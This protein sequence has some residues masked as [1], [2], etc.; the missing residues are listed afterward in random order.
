MALCKD[1]VPENQTCSRIVTLIFILSIFGCIKFANFLHSSANVSRVADAQLSS[2]ASDDDACARYDVGSIR[3]YLFGAIPFFFLMMFVEYIVLKWSKMPSSGAQFTAVDTWSSIAMGV[4]QVIVLEV[5]LRAVNVRGFYCSIFTRFHDKLFP[6]SVPTIIGQHSWLGY[7][8][9]I[10]ADDFVYYWFHRWSHQYGWLW[11]GHQVHHSS[12]HFNLSTALR[13]SYWQAIL[14]SLT[15]LIEAPFFHPR[16]HFTVNMWVT[17]YQ[18]YFHTCTIRRFD[19]FP[20]IEYIMNTPSHHRVHHDRRV[21][22]NFGGIFIIWD[23]IFGT[24]RDER[25]CNAVGAVL[26]PGSDALSSGAASSSSSS[27]SLPNDELSLFG[28]YDPVKSWTEVVTQIQWLVDHGLRHPISLWKGPGYYTATKERVLPAISREPRFRQDDRPRG[29]L[30]NV[31]LC[32][33]FF[34]IFFSVVVV[35]FAP[36]ATFGQY[37]AASAFLL[38]GLFVQGLVADRNF[39]TAV[40]CEIGR[41]LFSMTAPFLSSAALLPSA[42]PLVGILSILCIALIWDRRR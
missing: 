37:F 7:F 6:F 25:E 15:R 29:T 17:N 26:T 30:T 24:F 34:W 11:A 41:L 21:H 28:I 33:Y 13:Q 38:L 42:T 5:F 19:N 16:V 8:V 31:Y 4:T 10:V 14:G 40:V 20:L 18:F 1:P 32:V 39:K 22:K 23:R 36:E 12:E 35:K 3:D 2:D 27:L 9:A